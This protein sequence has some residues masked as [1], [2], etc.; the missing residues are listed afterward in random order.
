MESKPVSHEILASVVICTHNRSGYLEKC[1]ESLFKSTL[2]RP[3]TEIIVVNNASTDA[4]AEVL[5]HLEASHQELRSVVEPRLGLSFARNRGVQEARGR[6]V[7]FLDDD[8]VVSRHWLKTITA[9]FELDPGL[10]GVGGRIRP[11]FESGR[12]IW[13]LPESLRFFGDFDLGPQEMDVEWIPGG[14]SAW[15]RTFLIEHGEFDVTLGRFGKS[16]LG[17]SEESVVARTA[18]RLGSRLSYSPKALM[19]HRIGPEKTKLVWLVTRYFGQGL[20]WSKVILIEARAKASTIQLGA[21]LESAFRSSGARMLSL[22]GA[23]NGKSR[24]LFLRSLFVAAELAGKVSGVAFEYRHRKK[25][26]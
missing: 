6:F 21:L 4:T 20:M 23:R 17:G 25:S 3:D 7:A 2:N 26:P 24:F 11:V 15:S 12:P 10:V 18:I 13:I 19:F 9:P 1:L 16:P 14:N 5:G 22:W 8:G